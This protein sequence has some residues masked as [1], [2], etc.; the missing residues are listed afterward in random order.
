MVISV[1]YSSIILRGRSETR[2]LSRLD[3]P[4]GQILRNLFREGFP[5]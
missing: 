4:G 5:P 2:T 1:I 3:V